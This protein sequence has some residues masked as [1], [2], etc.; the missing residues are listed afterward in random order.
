[1]N[2]PI[3]NQEKF[4][5]ILFEK[6][7]QNQYEFKYLYIALSN[8]IE[9]KK[10]AYE[11]SLINLENENW[12]LIIHS[13]ELL[14]YGNH[15]TE[16]QFREINQ[17]IDLN[18]YRNYLLSG[19]SELIFDLINYYKISNFKI[20]KER[21]FFRTSKISDTII[22]N[23]EI[24]IAKYDETNKLSLMLQQYY[25]EEYNGEN[26]KTDN[27]AKNRIRELITNQKIFVIENNSKEIVS[28]CTIINP[29]IGILFTDEKHR[30]NGYG[31]QILS[32]CSNKLLNENNEIYLMTDKKNNEINSICKKIGYESYCEY[33]YVRINNS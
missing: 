1:M 27:E 16:T 3:T 22:E 30:N 21:L 13:D 5:K 18:K 17:I 33:A 4:N 7:K 2:I 10:I 9:G 14:I 28:F 24:R 11:S 6:I 12:I 25:H 29:E 15:W 20:E 26:D 19:K 23:C 8:I 32:Y 31:K